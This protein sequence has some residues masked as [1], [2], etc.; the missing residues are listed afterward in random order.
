[1]T[2]SIQVNQLDCGY[3]DTAVLRRVDLSVAAGRIHALIGLNGA[4][5][6]TLMRSVLGTLTPRSGTVTVFGQSAATAGPAVWRRVGYLLG[7]GSC[8]AELTGRENIYSAARLH[9]LSRAAARRD[10]EVVIGAFGIE[11]EAGKRTARLSLGNR[12]RVALAAAFAHRPELLVL[13]EPTIGLDPLAV[14]ALR[15]MVRT[16]VADRHAAILVSSH[17]LDE[18]ARI[19]DDIT[20]IH[21]GR[22]IAPLDPG[23]VDLEKRFFDLVY[24]A[25]LEGD[26]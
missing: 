12:Q 20:V 9:G 5:K 15:R 21:R 11:S 17:H 23:G 16:A 4:G 26:S 2:T 24:A 18:V 6:T 8:Y 3:G 19:A 13:D 14:L 25:E 10:A 22:V 7:T 1:M